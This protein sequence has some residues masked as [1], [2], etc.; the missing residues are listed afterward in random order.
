AV[1][2][3]PTVLEELDRA[4]GE[5]AGSADVVL[6]QAELFLRQDEVAFPKDRDKA[7][8]RARRHLEKACQDMPDHVE[9]WVALANVEGAGDPGR[10]LGVL[11]KAAEQPKL[12][13]RAELGAA[14]A[15]LLARLPEKE[16]RPGLK[17]LVQEAAAASAEQKPRLLSGLADAYLAM[18]A[19]ADAAR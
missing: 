14:R 5:R 4:A 18:G 1:R 11:A 17:Q 8:E 2:D 10:G 7:S 19:V 9:L 13:G 16:A 15:R 6:L 12:G 3:W